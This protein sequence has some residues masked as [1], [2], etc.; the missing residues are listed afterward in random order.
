MEREKHNIFM[1]LVKAVNVLLIWCAWLW[2]TQVCSV[3]CLVATRVVKGAEIHLADWTYI[4]RCTQA[5]AP[6][7]VFGKI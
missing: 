3:F 6:M 2:F 1:I 4:D 7:T 5:A